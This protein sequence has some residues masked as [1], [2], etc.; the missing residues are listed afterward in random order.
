L[1]FSTLRSDVGFI[2][3]AILDSLDLFS[4]AAD[5]SAS[6][7]ELSLELWVVVLVFLLL[8]P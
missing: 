6:L 1:F 4:S 7:E 8:E 2:I 3:I 5:P